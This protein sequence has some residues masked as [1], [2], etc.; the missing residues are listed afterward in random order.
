MRHSSF[1]LLLMLTIG[2]GGV[3]MRRFDFPVARGIKLHE[4]D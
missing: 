1:G 3:L 2:W 4:D